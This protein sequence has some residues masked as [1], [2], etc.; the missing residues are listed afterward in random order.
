MRIEA[1]RHHRCRSL[2]GPHSGHHAENSVF[3]QTQVVITGR[4]RK[5]LVKMLAFYPELKFTRSVTGVLAALK[6]G[7]HDDFDTNRPSLHC[8]LARKIVAT[9]RR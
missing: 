7:H 2:G 5:D 1:Q 3:I 8:G 4:Q 6:H 9:D